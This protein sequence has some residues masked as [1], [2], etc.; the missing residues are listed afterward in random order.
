[1]KICGLLSLL[2]TVAP[3]LTTAQ[4]FRHSAGA[5]SFRH[6]IDSLRTELNK[7]KADTTRARLLA[8][9][10]SCYYDTDAD[11]AL[12]YAR[13]AVDVA[14][15]TSDLKLKLKC[16]SLLA[17]TISERN[18]PK[19]M[20]MLLD[21]LQQAEQ[22]SYRW[23]IEDCYNN[24]ALLQFYLE[25]YPQ[26]VMYFKRARQM[27]LEDGD[28]Q[29]ASHLSA[30]MGSAFL[31]LH[32][33]DS[34]RHYLSLSIQENPASEQ[35]P[36]TLYYRGRLETDANPANARTYFQRSIRTL[37]AQQDWRGLAL[38]SRW[39][40]ELL[41]KQHQPDSSILVAKAGLRAGQLLGNL[42]TVLVNSR[43][44]AQVYRMLGQTDSA[45]TYQTT[46]LAAQDSLFSQ[47]KINQIQ[48]TLIE[49]QQ[50]EQRLEEEKSQFENRVKLYGLLGIMSVL[51]LL[52]GV[53][54]RNDRQ[55]QRSNG[56]LRTLNREVTEQKEELQTQRD[57]L[58]QTLTEL[59]ATQAQLIQS[60]KLASL[61]ELT[62]GIAH[63]IQNPLN[64]V[65]NFSEVSTELVGELRE[66]REK[67][68][69]GV[70]GE[71]DEGLERELLDDLT[72]NLQKIT[73]HGG[74]ASAIVRGMLE[75][76][77][78]STGEK[79]PTNLNELADEYLRLSYH[80]L[81]AQDKT[82]SAYR[83]NAKLI[84]HFDPALPIIE[85][86]SQ[87]IG[88]V[89]QNLFNNAFYAVRH[90]QLTA[91]ADYQPTVT[92]STQV[93]FGGRGA[94]IRV[95]DNGMGIPDS[96]KAKIFQPFFTTKPTGEG[97][98]LGLSLAY[99]IVTKGHGGTLTVNTAENE[100][101]EFVITLP[102]SAGISVT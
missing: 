24:M 50:R 42:R 88:R 57:Q 23:V 38:A 16:K 18:I 7:A 89:L 2:L 97:T 8:E 68:R 6:T 46:M 4:S 79:Q 45:Y 22:I 30:E 93:S 81:L 20:R 72:Q 67:G 92:V 25:N 41:W 29:Y 82:D 76:S 12:L 100:F 36:Y 86:V 55:K 1:M 78:T 73:H 43:Q 39:Y 37:D 83:F 26:T 27:A 58:S 5:E 35:S 47:Q 3:L 70:P 65:N 63:E 101:T 69:A 94:E 19:S 77:R 28:S 74:R 99:D 91:P 90:K 64:F 32:Q 51:L 40:S 61:G 17:T 49:E 75:H 9:A 96:V 54:Y 95:H 52:A 98:G 84:T 48:T 10:G 33:A 66:E 44:L 71:R 87:D 31:G 14:R 13:Q 80:G 11:S 60:E 34:A 102:A 59:H 15:K 53:F 62:A 85:I 56:Q 21:V